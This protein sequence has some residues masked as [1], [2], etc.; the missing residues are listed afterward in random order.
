MRND[1]LR[2]PFH[3][4]SQLPR[5]LAELSHIRIHAS[6]GAVGTPESSTP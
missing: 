3:V 2:T 4:D 6:H 1:S 5:S